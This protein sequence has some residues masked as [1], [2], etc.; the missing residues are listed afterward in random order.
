MTGRELAIH[1]APDAF[2]LFTGNEAVRWRDGRHST[3]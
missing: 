2:D 3:P 1:Q